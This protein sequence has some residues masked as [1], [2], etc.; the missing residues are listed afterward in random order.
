VGQRFSF[1][2]AFALVWTG[3]LIYFARNWIESLIGL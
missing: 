3:F 2:S 1:A